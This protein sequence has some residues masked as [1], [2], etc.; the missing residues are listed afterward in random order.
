MFSCSTNDVHIILDPVPRVD[1]FCTQLVFDVVFLKAL[2]RQCFAT[3]PGLAVCCACE[4]CCNRLVPTPLNDSRQAWSP[5]VITYVSALSRYNLPHIECYTVLTVFSAATSARIAI[6]NAPGVARKH[7]MV[8]LSRIFQHSLEELHVYSELS[9]AGM[10]L[11]S[12]ILFHVPFYAG[13]ANACAR[14]RLYLPGSCVNL[15]TKR[16]KGEDTPWGI[17]SAL[18]NVHTL[19]EVGLQ[20]CLAWCRW[21][22]G[23]CFLQSYSARVFHCSFV[24]SWAWLGL[25][26][27]LHV[28]NTLSS[29][30]LTNTC[31]VL[32]CAATPPDLL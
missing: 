2:V 14:H 31:H 22:C 21:H 6:A 12:E 32:H 5:D 7:T 30:M 13:N 10:E 15:V 11:R 26:L 3:A 25:F 24:E 20:W 8:Y 29:Q 19:A 9:L 17:E 23:H 28:T 16:C 27:V 18:C 4:C 1:L